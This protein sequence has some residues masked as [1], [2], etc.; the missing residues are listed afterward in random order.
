MNNERLSKKPMGRFGRILGIFG[1]L[2]A[3]ITALTPGILAWFDNT[4]ALAHKEAKES[5]LVAE[6]SE[7]KVELA[8]EL[9]KQRLEFV[10]KQLDETRQDVKALQRLITAA[11]AEG[12]LGSRRHSV[13]SGLGGGGGGITTERELEELKELDGLDLGALGEGSAKSEKPRSP[14]EQKVLPD[15]EDEWK[16]REQKK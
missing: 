12:H 8:Y 11:M 10:E 14:P 6:K 15:L 4:G 5:S 3:L 9:V 13:L 7:E 1:A 2:A 16:R